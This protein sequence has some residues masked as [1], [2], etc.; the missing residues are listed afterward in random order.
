MTHQ[1]QTFLSVF[2]PNTNL[3]LSFFLLYNLRSELIKAVRDK[4]EIQ[5]ILFRL[6]GRIALNLSRCLHLPTLR[7]RFE[8]LYR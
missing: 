3:E 8:Q 2:N 1:Q 5:F 4:L 7:Q 6:A